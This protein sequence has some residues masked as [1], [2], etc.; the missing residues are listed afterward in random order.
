MH[1]AH[2][3]TLALSTVETPATTT[4][5]VFTHI[6]GVAMLVAERDQQG[7]WSFTL[8]AGV[9]DESEEKLLEWAAD[10]MPHPAIAIGWQVG[11]HMVPVLIDAIRQAE[12][13]VAH[14][15]ASRLARL[16]SAPSIDPAIDH[17]GAGASPFAEIAAK[18]GLTVPTMDEEQRFNAWAFSWLD[19]VRDQITQE[20]VALWQFWLHRSGQHPDAAIATI[21][22]LSGRS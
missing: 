13:E 7:E 9:A 3:V 21:D 8:H 4:M 16:F 6:I 18:I 2:Y 17:G 11:D 10:L 20:A 1:T 5:P 15:V 22:W 12:P 14:H 19:P